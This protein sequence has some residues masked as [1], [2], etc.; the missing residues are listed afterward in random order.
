MKILITIG[1]VIIFISAFFILVTGNALF[2]NS[3]SCVVEDNKTVCE[4]D[5]FSGPV[6][7]SIII[8]LFFI[9][10]DAFSV[11]LILSNLSSA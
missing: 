6:M 9:V 8:I 7:L 1:M 3:F 5:G 4:F 2:N 11:Y 10:I